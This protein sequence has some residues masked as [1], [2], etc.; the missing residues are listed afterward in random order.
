MALLSPFSFATAFLCSRSNASSA[1]LRFFCSVWRFKTALSRASLAVLTCCFAR[2]FALSLSE[3]SSACWAVASAFFA[4]STAFC[5]SS[6]SFFFGAFLRHS[7]AAFFRMR[8]ASPMTTA[9]AARLR[10]AVAAAAASAA[11]ASGA[12][13]SEAVPMPTAVFWIAV[14][15]ASPCAGAVGCASGSG[16]ASMLLRSLSSLAITPLSLMGIG[17]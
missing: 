14:A 15:T 8:T 6:S 2:A 1:S 17:S 4:S 16:I 3:S 13:P 12:L 10:T 11:T 5:A 7:A 9:S